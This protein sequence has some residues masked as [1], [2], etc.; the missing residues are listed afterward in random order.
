[1]TENSSKSNPVNQSTSSLS[2]RMNDSTG[3]TTS[4][5]INGE[6]KNSR[7]TKIGTGLR[8]IFRRFSRTNK[9]LTEMEIQI[10]S[11]RTN[12]TREEVLEW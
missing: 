2:S 9:S 8:S 5:M 10:L 12:F 7:S 1:M 4:T 11:T 6:R 3:A